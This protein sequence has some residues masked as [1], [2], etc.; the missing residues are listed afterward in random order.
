MFSYLAD[1][2]V[3]SCNPHAGVG[4]TF[5][6]FP[7]WYKYLPGDYVAGKC[8]PTIDLINHPIQI[9]AIGLAL[10]EILLR[11]AVLVAIGFVVSG[12]VQYMTSQGE[13]DKTRRARGT[14]INALIGM[15]IAVGAI[16]LV[17][18]LGGQFK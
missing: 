17:T 16:T 12:G 4:G 3:N 15:V 2:A 14:I 1:L 8:T 11:V 5:F 18:F 10:L 13:P 9:A 6:G 7:T